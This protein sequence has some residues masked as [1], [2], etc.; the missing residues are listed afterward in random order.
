MLRSTVDEDLYK[1]VNASLDEDQ[2]ILHHCECRGELPGMPLCTV[3]GGGGGATA[4][5]PVNADTTWLLQIPRPKSDPS[6]RAYFNIILDPWLAGPQSDLASWF[7]RQWHAIS[8]AYETVPE[9]EELCRRVEAIA[10]SQPGSSAAANERVIDAIAISHE[11]TDHCHKDTLVQFGRDVPVIATTKAADLIRG[12]GHFDQ[13][14][15]T[16]PFGGEEGAGDARRA[17]DHGADWRRTRMN[18]L[19]PWLTISRVVTG[20]DAFYYHSA[21]LFAFHL[22]SHREA[23][24]VIYTPH[25]IRAN[26]LNAITTARPPLQ[27]LAML[28]GL[29]DVRIDWGQQLNLGAHNGLKAQRALR[30]RY[31]LGTH[32][33]VKRGGGIVSWF[34][35]RKVWSVADALDQAEDEE[36]K[37]LFGGEYL[38]LANGQSLVL[39]M[40]GAE[41]VDEVNGVEDEL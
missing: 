14:I 33:E 41:D 10:S 36:G 12:W 13:V 18:A 3:E 27:T 32:D 9:V 6:Y 39:T 30:A 15:E 28:H 25:G 2:P 5:I 8:S 23:Q 31:W 4:L 11:F 22:E 35:R 26:S 24:C 38:E 1:L 16:P 17:N 19:P 34:L 40:E 21:I 29:H 37:G 7:S 20:Q